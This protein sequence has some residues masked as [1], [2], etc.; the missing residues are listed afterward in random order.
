LSLAPARAS[1]AS[2]R[3]LAGHFVFASGI[4][5]FKRAGEPRALG[6][7]LGEIGLHV[8]QAALRGVE[9]RFGFGQLARQSCG[10][11]ARSV[12]RGLLRALFVLKHQQPLA[13]GIEFGFERD[14]ALLGGGEPLVE[15]AVLVAQRVGF[16]GLLR[17]ARFQIGD[18]HAA[19]ATRPGLPVQLVRGGGSR[20]GI[21][22]RTSKFFSSS[23]TSLRLAVGGAGVGAVCRLIFSDFSA[24]KARSALLTGSDS[25]AT[26]ALM[27]SSS[28]ILALAS[29][30]RLRSVSL[31]PP[32]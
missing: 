27:V 4:G 3:A 32:I 11:R 19:Q 16:P 2:N 23:A 26:A 5:L 17:Q 21:G 6:I 18:L 30:S 29:S 10:F 31:S 25:L 12:E 1:K 24:S 22:F 13:P 7:H 9:A 14:D 20:A 8:T 28:P 15:P